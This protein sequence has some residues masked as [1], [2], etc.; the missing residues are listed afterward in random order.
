MSQGI[1]LRKLDEIEKDNYTYV[2]LFYSHSMGDWFN[3]MVI[4]M[5]FFPVWIWIKWISKNALSNSKATKNGSK[6]IIESDK[7]KEF[8][9]KGHRP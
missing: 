3:W 7:N 8:K 4:N 1:D 2:S 5:V 6:W 9:A